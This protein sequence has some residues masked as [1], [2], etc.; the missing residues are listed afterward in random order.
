MGIRELSLDQTLVLRLLRAAYCAEGELCAFEALPEG[1]DWQKVYEAAVQ[2]GVP[3][4][5]LDGLQRLMAAHPEWAWELDWPEWEEVKYEWFGQIFLAEEQYRKYQRAIGSL[6]AF[7]QQHGIPMMVLKGYSCS[8][9]YPVPEHR[10]CGDIDIWLFGRYKEADALLA[11]EKG[12]KIDTT[13]HHHTV[14]T[15]NGQMVEN[16]YDLINVHDRKSSRALERIFKERAQDSSV[17]VVVSGAQIVV[18]APTFHALFLIRH[19]AAHFSAVEIQ[20]RH[21][22][23]WGFWVKAHAGEIDWQWLSEKADRFGFLPFMSLVDAI[24]VEDLGFERWLFPTLPVDPALKQRV[25]AEILQPEFSE[26]QPRGFVR[27]VLFKYRRWHVGIWKHRLCYRETAWSSFWSS[28][29]AH[30]LKPGSI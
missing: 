20:L 25:L 17:Q 10:P 29:W 1:L 26:P 4:V 8:L 15:W 14:F 9:G 5:A 2:H 13:H 30:L 23:D 24:C 7:Y 16:H 3:A 21:L 11:K 28:A 27:R 22:L 12:V 18:L 19:A 6:A